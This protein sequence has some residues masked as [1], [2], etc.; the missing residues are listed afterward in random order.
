[1]T[2]LNGM[3][4]LLESEPVAAAGDGRLN[5]MDLLLADDAGKQ[6]PDMPQA[7]PQQ[8]P[9]PE[10]WGQWA[11]NSVVGRQDPRE[12]NTGTVYEQFEPELRNTTVNAALAGADDAGMADIIRKSLGDRFIRQEQDANGNPIFVT[13]TPEGGEQRG[14]VNR[15]GIDTQDAWRAFWGAVPYVVGGVGAGQVM[16]GA[17]IGLNTMA[18][19]GTAGVT[20]FAQQV[21]A[22][23]QGSEQGYDQLRT[24]T[25]TALGAAGP[26]LAAAGSALW[27]RF[28]TIPGLYDS[29]AGR[30]TAKG[31]DLARRQG[32][33]PDQL[34]SDI[35]R[36]FAKSVAETGDEA[37]AATRAGLD[38]YGISASRGQVTKDP[39]LLTQ[40]EAMRRRLYGEQAQDIMRGF[41]EKQKQQIADAAFGGNNLTGSGRKGIGEQINPTRRSS[42]PIER[43]PADLGAS[44][45]DAV[46]TARQGARKAEEQL[47]DDGVRN[48]A[49]TDKALGNLRPHMSKALADETDFTGTGEKMAKAI[50]EFADGDLPVSSAGGIDLKQVKSVDQMRR[51]LYG[52]MS[53]AEP[54]T[55]DKRQAGKIY[56]AF[57]DWIGESAKNK[58]LEGDPAAALR[59]VKARGFHREIMDLFEPTAKDGSLS[60]AGR[61]LARVL[62]DAKADSGEAV[63][64]ALFGA[65]GSRSASDGVVGALQN[66]RNSL[67]K[68]APQQAEQA[69]D[70]IGLAFWSRL[71]TNKA[72][73]ILGPQALA[74][75]IKTALAN[76]KSIMRVLYSPEEAREIRLFL[77]AI[78]TVAYKP[79]NASGSGYTAAS[80]IK[81]AL[82]KVLEAF[83]LGGAARAVIGAS[84]LQNA[85]GRYVANQAVNRIS[86]PTRPNITPLV[87]STG[88]P[89]ARSD[90][91]SSR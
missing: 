10:S 45:Q 52:M 40:E 50:G 65:Q 57:N 53:G 77:R 58:L 78:E 2:R 42:S 80:L 13:R 47:W 56:A 55:A 38:T 12:A 75:N 8:Q 11:Y 63:I 89:Y 43:N 46:Q 20:D 5:G 67:L 17:G 1:M 74:T 54:G 25:M 66:V 19:G 39:Y 30:L 14:Y 68:F 62:D 41:D 24:G 76:Q 87:T 82:L 4:L 84:P 28:V 26:P 16:R 44:V 21:A 69:W 36:G 51:R 61:R 90:D 85:L 73:E 23:A 35:A 59:L 37:L 22:Q 83:G 31:A 64:N 34:S 91:Q 49:A 48:L 71:V 33:D 32:I 27:R 15:P 86:R 9:K 70:D 3:D 7:A 6:Q 81:D 72:G 79:P 29:T 60:P 88:Q 18:Q